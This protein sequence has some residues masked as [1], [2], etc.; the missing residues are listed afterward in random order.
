MPDDAYR[1]PV[2]K[3][4]NPNAIRDHL[5]N[6]R[7]LLAWVRSCIAIMALGFVVARFG[8]LIRELGP[9]APRRTPAWLSTGFGVAMVACGAVLVVLAALRHRTTT[10][11][12]EHGDYRPGTSLILVLS[13]GTVVV[14]VLLAVY[15]LLTA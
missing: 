15:L 8:L 12:I 7:T 4:A 6:E 14:A 1:N 10:Q 2:E 5:A 13:A 11:A 9:E 3:P